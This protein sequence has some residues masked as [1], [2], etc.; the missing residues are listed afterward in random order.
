MRRW[1]VVVSL[2]V[3]LAALTTGGALARGLVPCELLQSQP[4]CYVAMRP[5]PAEDV[6]RLLEVSG[7]RS[8]PSTGELLLTTV[9][10]D[11]DLGLAEWLRSRASG[12]VE[13]V[14]RDQV[15][16]PGSDRDE[17][18]EYNAALMADS[19]LTATLAA[20]DELGFEV[21]G[22]GAL[23][24]AVVEDAVTD[25]LEVGD[26][27]VAV[28]GHA[29]TDNRGVVTAVQARAPG[30]RLALEVRR[31]DASRDVEVVLGAASDDALRPY[32]GVL[33]ST[34]LDLPVEVV[35]D[36]GVIGG[37]SAGLMF[38]LS[39]VEALGPEDL[40]DGTV[41][42]GTGTLSRDGE[43]GAIGGIQQKVLGATARADGGHGADVFLVPRGNLDQAVDTPVTSDVLLV[44]VGTL[45]EALAALDALAR[46]EVPAD[47]VALPGANDEAGAAS[48]DTAAAR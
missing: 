23:V 3:A 14:P 12:V 26:V 8:Y 19:Q 36:A 4:A 1:S 21:V 41:V 45:D 10:V 30:D 6:L 13:T 5:G 33:L 9:A 38:A 48:R 28:D 43:V 42:A 20:L 22:E 17:V 2:V 47:A 44:P 25:E 31:G 40:T 35:I 7:A 15:F 46:D 24:T 34:E 37:P 32:V 29:V 18:A 27:I 39:I 11:E 16:P